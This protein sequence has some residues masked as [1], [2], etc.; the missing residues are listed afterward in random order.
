MAKLPEECHPAKRL[1]FNMISGDTTSTTQR[2]DVLTSGM[3][4][5]KGTA[6]AATAAVPGV[7]VLTPG[8]VEVTL[9][10]I[11]L[12]PDESNAVRLDLQNGWTDYDGDYGKANYVLL[13]NICVLQGL[14]RDGVQTAGTLI[15]QLPESCRPKEKRLI[16]NMNVQD[17][18]GRFLLQKHQFRSVRCL[19]IWDPGSGGENMSE[20]RLPRGFL[21]ASQ[22]YRSWMQRLGTTPATP[23]SSL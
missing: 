2:V 17:E 9:S 13:D 20:T 12:V 10:G 5:W 23:K 7:P 19:D 15:A 16:F 18:V 4:Y 1:I 3:L 22:S 11:L 21:E 14:I 6:P 8:F